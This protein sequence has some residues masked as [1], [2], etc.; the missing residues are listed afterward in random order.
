MSDRLAAGSEPLAAQT[1]AALTERLVKTGLDR[2]QIDLLLSLYGPVIFGGDALLIAWRIPPSIVDDLTPLVAEPEPQKTVRVV[3][4]VAR[5]MDPVIEQ[6]MQVLADQ[7]GNP[8]YKVRE[9]AEDKLKELGSL[10][11]PVLRKSMTAADPEVAFR[12]E[13]LLLGQK[14]NIDQ[15]NQPQDQ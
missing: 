7:L 6:T 3:L 8:Q 9:A 2:K 11:W 14:Q 5:N 4:V 10:A 15:P 1:T 13:R 12:A